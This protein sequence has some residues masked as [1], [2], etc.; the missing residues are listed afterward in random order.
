VPAAA[1]LEGRAA[2]VGRGR[3]GGW[4][5]RRSGWKPLRVGLRP[6]V[7]SGWSHSNVGDEG[8]AGQGDSNTPARCDLRAKVKPR[9]DPRVPRC[10]LRIR[11]RS[12][13]PR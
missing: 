13:R 8:P 7:V 9:R 5:G 1:G 4:K 12:S 11:F 10:R 2:A 3:R 6:L